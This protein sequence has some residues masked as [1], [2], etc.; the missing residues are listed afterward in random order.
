M[1]FF[2]RPQAFIS[3]NQLCKAFL[4]M[5]TNRLET[6]TRLKASFSGQNA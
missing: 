3:P 1:E 4:H 2:Y 5:F 6:D